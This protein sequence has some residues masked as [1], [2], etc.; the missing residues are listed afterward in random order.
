V[1]LTNTT[2]R[3]PSEQKWYA[4]TGTIVDAKAEADGDIH[5]A[6]QDPTGDAVGTISAEI[7]V[8]LKWCE[9]RQIVFGWTQ[10]QFPFRVRSGRKLEIAQ[11]PITAFWRFYEGKSRFQRWQRVRESN[12]CT[13][14]ERAVS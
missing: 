14:L 13:S 11:T 12:P 5:L 4:V 6:L 1:E 7:P 8:G 2:E 3:L 9:I 10:V